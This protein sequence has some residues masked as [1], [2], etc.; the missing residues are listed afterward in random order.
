VIDN[1]F[2]AVS[3]RR[4]AN[5]PRR[6]I[7]D[8][9]LDRL[10]VY[11]DAQGLSL[12]QSLEF[13]EQA[14][15]A[16]AP[17]R[18]VQALRTLLQSLMSAAQEL[19][20]PELLERVLERSGCLET[21][22]AERT[23]EARGR[24]ENLQ[25]LV[26][27]TREYLEQAQEPSL[28]G[29]LQEISL[30]SDQDAIRGEE[31]LVTL[32][33]LHNAKG[34]E[35]RAVFMI[36]MEEGVFPHARSIEEQGIEEERRLAYVGMTRAK[37]RLVLTHASARSLWGNRTYNL[38]SRFLD[39]LPE[40]GVVR[41]RL[42]PA[43]WESVSRGVQPRDDVPSLS[44]GDSVRHGSL[45]EGVVVRVEPGGIVTVRF[46]EDGAERRLMLDYAPLEKIGR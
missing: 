20:V 17:L 27:V 9:T 41:E 24:I 2:D 33:T 19:S 44:T 14:G 1:P 26:G 12:W 22:E 10:Q 40:E 29:F 38:P 6:G 7:G 42:R 43:T 34:L 25:E 8:T 18:A 28:S 5:R 32:M 31:T 16:A 23:I 4:I 36:G 45:G 30:Y 13:A 46:E 39:E 11:A 15:V 3:L 37:E 35:F 21:L